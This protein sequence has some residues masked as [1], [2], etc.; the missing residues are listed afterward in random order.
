MAK[1]KR[2]RREQRKKQ[3]RLESE[4]EGNVRNS[5]ETALTMETVEREE[6]LKRH[7]EEKELLLVTIRWRKGQTRVEEGKGA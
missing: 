7:M 5:V 2:L 1:R 3:A 4:V 6:R